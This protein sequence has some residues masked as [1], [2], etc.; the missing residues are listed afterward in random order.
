MLIRVPQLFF[1]ANYSSYYL[2]LIDSEGKFKYN[3]QRVTG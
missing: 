1:N 2:R 3:L